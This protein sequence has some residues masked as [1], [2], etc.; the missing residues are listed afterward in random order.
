MKRH[1]K[2]LITLITLLLCG[3]MLFSITACSVT[4]STVVQKPMTARPT[5]TNNN[6][7]RTEGAIFN[8]AAYRPLFEDRKPRFVGDI[9]TVRISE[10]TNATKTTDSEATKDGSHKSGITSLFS[11]ATPKAEFAGSSATSVT[12]S[13]TA[14]ASN[15]FNGLVTATVIEVLPNGFLVISGEKQISLDKGTEFVRFSGVV[16]PD[17]ITLGNEVS[18]NKIAD[19]RIEYRTNSKI[20]AAEAV[21]MFSRFFLS[22]IPF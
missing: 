9:L 4:P 14:N 12:D 1:L 7:Q 3:L 20:D 2:T 13:A 5:A 10:T 19:A 16:N 11:F 8:Q 21:S 17:T 18:S 15:A 22:M 6:N